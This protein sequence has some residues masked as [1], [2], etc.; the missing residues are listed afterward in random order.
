[1]CITQYLCF[2]DDISIEKLQLKILHASLTF[3][4]SLFK[5]NLKR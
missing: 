5:D 2:A 1:M 3:A 4:S